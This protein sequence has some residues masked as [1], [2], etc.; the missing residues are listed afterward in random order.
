MTPTASRTFAPAELEA[1]CSDLLRRAGASEATALALA[2]ATVEAEQRGR[3]AV[4]V[5]HLLDYVTALRDGRLNAHASPALIGARPSALVVD[6]DGGT[7]QL[8]FERFL[9]DLVDAAESSGVAVLSLNNAF[10]TGELGFYV[11]RLTAAGLIGLVCG[12]SPAL[13]S[14]YGSREPVT[15]T[16]PLAFGVPQRSGA[17]AFDQA[18]SATAW[19]NVRDAAE[20]AEPIPEGWATDRYG[21]PTTDAA[22]ALDGSLLPFGGVKGANIA[23][24]V[25]LLATLA[26]GS[27]SL[28]ATG[29]VEGEPPRLGL[30]ALA[31]DP[32]AFDA[33]ALDR[34]EQ[35]FARDD[36]P[37]LPSFGRPRTP[38]TLIDIDES[39]LERLTAAAE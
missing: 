11:R 21:E 18:S 5:R 2:A 13:L 12:N 8:A 33:G 1:F 16:N 28:D 23:I 36:V 9:P 3:P 39:L 20:R 10:T 14:V 29:G 19:V 35:H 15:G 7:A 25:E 22:A 30:F 37:G 4:G 31:I 26:G 32:T 38:L 27:F 17:R 24:M 6:A 34:V